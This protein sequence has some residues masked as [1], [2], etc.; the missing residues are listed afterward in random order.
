MGT[1][2]YRRALQMSTIYS[3]PE[4]FLPER[5]LSYYDRFQSGAVSSVEIGSTN[6]SSH[7]VWK[8]PD[9]V[10]IMQPDLSAK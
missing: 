1:K 7:A 10:I 9:T 6:K 5:L 8:T 3:D 4:G 2:L